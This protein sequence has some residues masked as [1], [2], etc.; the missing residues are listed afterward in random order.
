M[1]VQIMTPGSGVQPHWQVQYRVMQVPPRPW[2][3]WAIASS[4]EDADG[5]YAKLME[6]IL[7]GHEMRLVEYTGKVLERRTLR[8]AT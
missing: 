1:T 2:R 7:P 3:V 4:R 8:H 5:K 6:Q